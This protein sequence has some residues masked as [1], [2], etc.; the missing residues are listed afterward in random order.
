MKT[1]WV[2]RDTSGNFWN[3]LYM[4]FKGRLY[5]TKF[6]S[7]NEAVYSV[8]AIIL[9]GKYNGLFIEEMYIKE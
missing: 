4:R 2:I 8:N 6:D 3:Y 9:D 7:K 5:A 1:V